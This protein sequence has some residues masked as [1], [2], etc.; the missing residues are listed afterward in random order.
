M[1]FVALKAN[2]CIDLRED[3]LAIKIDIFDKTCNLEKIDK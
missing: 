3:S 2:S 1:A